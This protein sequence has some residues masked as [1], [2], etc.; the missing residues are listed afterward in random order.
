V[1]LL[2][3]SAVGAGDA[4]QSRL[5]PAIRAFS[6]QVYHLP[7]PAG[8][9]QLQPEMVLLSVRVLI[10][11]VGYAGPSQFLHHCQLLLVG[12]IFIEQRRRLSLNGG[13]VRAGRVRPV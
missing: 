8:S 10:I 4:A 2:L 3:E 6:K 13:I 5:L 1:A 9:L 7:V 11:E 12:G